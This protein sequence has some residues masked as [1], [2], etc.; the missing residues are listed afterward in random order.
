MHLSSLPHVLVCDVHLVKNNILNGNKLWESIHIYTVK[1]TFNV[2][3]G[4]MDLNTEL[5]KILNGGTFNSG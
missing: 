2:P 1:F 3:L 4:A 5:R